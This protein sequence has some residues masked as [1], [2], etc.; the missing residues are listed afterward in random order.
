MLMYFIVFCGL[1]AALNFFIETEKTAIGA[2][3]VIAVLWGLSHGVFWGLVTVGELFLGYFV[4]RSVNNH[5]S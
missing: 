1:G 3:V 2:I 4:F 5:Q